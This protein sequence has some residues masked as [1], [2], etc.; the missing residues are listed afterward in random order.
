[1]SV[2][3]MTLDDGVA[4]IRI[5][6]G[7][8]NAVSQDFIAE[9]HAALDEAEKSADAIVIFGRPGR[10]S[11]G[12]DLKVMMNDPAAAGDLVTAGGQL[13]TR[14]FEYPKPV[15]AA[16]TGHAL[17]AGALLLLACDTRIGTQGDYKLGLNETAIGMTLPDYGIILPQAR[18]EPRHFT[19]A[20]IQAKIHSPEEA[21][22][23]GFLDA[24][25]DAD[26]LEETAMA[27]ANAL[28]TLPG[29]AYAGNKR[30][31]RKEAIAALHASFAS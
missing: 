27:T 22:E 30:K 2:L 13:F 21:M 9:M 20:V 12:F 29:P 28:K 4:V 19:S 6:D 31:I 5:D 1:M 3:T 24:V 16:C 10:F 17:A 8:A 7:K 18:L 15:I 26:A 14:I 23:A 11:A 25:A